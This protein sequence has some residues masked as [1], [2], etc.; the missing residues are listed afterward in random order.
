MVAYALVGTMRQNIVTEPLGTGA[1]GNP[2]YLKDIWPSSADIAELVRTTVT[3]DMFRTRYADV[4]QGDEHWK[5][6]SVSGR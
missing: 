1:D 2:V 6:I 5:T 3:E 4:F